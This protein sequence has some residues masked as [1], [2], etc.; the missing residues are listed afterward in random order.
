MEICVD[1]GVT[2]RP[3]AGCSLRTMSLTVAVRGSP[4]TSGT[5]LRSSTSSTCAGVRGHRCALCAKVGALTLSTISS[6]SSGGTSLSSSYSYSKGTSVFFRCSSWRSAHSTQSPSVLALDAV[7]GRDS[8]W[9]ALMRSS[10]GTDLGRMSFSSGT[11]ESSGGIKS[12][13]AEYPTI[14][15]SFG[16][17]NPVKISVTCT[18]DF[19]QY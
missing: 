11:A 8:C 5:F 17:Q 13:L 1:G 9:K 6:S 12:Y 16:N 10:P 3:R 14:K 2:C 15:A 7:V 4:L 19:L 18:T